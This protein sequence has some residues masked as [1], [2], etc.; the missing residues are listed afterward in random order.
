MTSLLHGRKRPLHDLR[1]RL[2]RRSADQADPQEEQHGAAADQQ[3]L[4]AADGPAEPGRSGSDRRVE[5]AGRRMGAAG[6]PSSGPPGRRGSA[7]QRLLSPTGAALYNG[8]VRYDPMP[9]G[10]CPPSLPIPSAPPPAAS[11]RLSRWTWPLLAALLVGAVAGVGVAA[12]IH[13][14]RVDSLADFTPSLV[15]Q[16]YDTRRRRLRDLRPRAPGDAQGE[17]DP[18][19]PAAGGARLRGR[20]LLPARRHRRHGHR[21]APRWPT[22]APARSSRAPRPSPCSSPARSSSP[23]SGPGGARSKRPS[24]PSSWRRTYSKQQILTLYLNLVN[25]GPRQLRGR[26]RLALLLRQA[27]RAS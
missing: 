12:A 21:A 10:S 8:A 2:T 18:P 4:A 13:V 22:C 19:G 17:R 11:R 27:G 7:W 20:Q 14:P 24:W 9:S 3:R 6:V 23:A 26:G 5:R 25:L 16:L 1:A 15:T